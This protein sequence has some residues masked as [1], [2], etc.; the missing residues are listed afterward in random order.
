MKFVISFRLDSV[1]LTEGCMLDPC[2]C[3]DVRTENI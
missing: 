2:Q 1:I 3:S